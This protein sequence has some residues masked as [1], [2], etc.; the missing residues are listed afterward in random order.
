MVIYFSDEFLNILLFGECS[1]LE[2]V[3]CVASLV[4]L[5]PFLFS[6]FLFSSPWRWFVGAGKPRS[7]CSK[8]ARQGGPPAAPFFLG[9]RSSWR[10]R[11]CGGGTWARMEWNS[12]STNFFYNAAWQPG[13]FYLVGVELS[14]K[15]SSPYTKEIA[16]LSGSVYELIYPWWPWGNKPGKLP[17]RGVLSCIPQWTGEQIQAGKSRE[18]LGSSKNACINPLFRKSDAP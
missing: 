18:R 2:S 17:A 7:D 13:L 8:R 9:G 5:F 6:F 1:H 3:D 4:A 12:F 15:L 16:F 11:C 10:P 14:W